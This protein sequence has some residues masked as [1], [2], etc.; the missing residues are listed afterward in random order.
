MNFQ[1]AWSTEWIQKYESPWGI[2]EKFKYANAI[3]GNIVLKLIGNEKVRN[4]KEISNA[5]RHHRDL[6]YFHGVD[7]K[8]S[9]KILG[10]NLKQYHD[11]L[12]DKSLY[13]FAINRS[14]MDYNFHRHLNYCPACLNTG[15]HSIFHQIKFFD[16][17]LFHPLQ[18]LIST[19]PKCKRS[20]PEYSIN[21]ENIDAY[22]CICGHY[23][24]KFKEYK[25][26]F[27]FMEKR[28]N[29]SK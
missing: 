4:F 19:C 11:Y 1:F 8:L 6:I 27:F 29:R 2:I 12:L 16:H 20:M 23:F 13:P 18:N 5:G 25:G 22:N 9:R 28:I 17:C 7:C 15:Y 26:H 14:N 24:F 3:N 21:K 10:V